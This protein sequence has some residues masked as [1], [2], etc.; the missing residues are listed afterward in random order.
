MNE[1][2]LESVKKVR[3]G[4]V[5]SNKM[6]KTVVVKVERLVKHKLYGKYLKTSVKYLADDP[7]SQ[8]NVGDII[9]IVECRPLSKRKRWRLQAI[10]EKAL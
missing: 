4:C 10:I 3:T 8:C 5:V 7:E 9:Q 6:Q 2:D 1:H